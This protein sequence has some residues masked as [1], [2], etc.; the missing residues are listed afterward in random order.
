[1]QSNNKTCG[2]LS[3]NSRYILFFHIHITNMNEFDHIIVILNYCQLCTKKKKDC[4]LAHHQKKT[5]CIYN[6]NNFHQ[7]S[8]TK[9]PFK[10]KKKKKHSKFKT[11][12]KL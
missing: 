4:Q 1:M 9:T 5:V 3:I 2:G 12:H 11:N 6:I 7:T 10:R 8:K